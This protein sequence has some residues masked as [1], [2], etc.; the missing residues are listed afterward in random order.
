MIR[1]AFGCPCPRLLYMLFY[2][3]FEES[4]MKLTEDQIELMASRIIRHLLREDL[5]E[6]SDDQANMNLVQRAIRE[7][8]QIEDKLNDEVREILPC[9]PTNSPVR[10][11]GKLPRLGQR[12]RHKGRRT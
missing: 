7:D 3:V 9:E 12:R 6:T 8:L 5:I 2:R 4:A 1:E 11:G 10:A